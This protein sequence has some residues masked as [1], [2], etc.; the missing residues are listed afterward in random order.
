MLSRLY[1][2]ILAG[3]NED[4]PTILGWYNSEEEAMQDGYSRLDIPFSV[5]GFYTSDINRVKSIL[6]SRRITQDGN[7]DRVNFRIRHKPLN[8]YR[9]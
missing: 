8:E 4:S 9:R 7:L 2:W 3:E 6:R 1:Y 5:K